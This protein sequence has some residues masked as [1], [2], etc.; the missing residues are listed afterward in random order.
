M[1]ETLN[2]PGFWIQW[3]RKRGTSNWY[4]Q[5]F[6]AERAVS[7]ADARRVFDRQKQEAVERS[8]PRLVPQ[9]SRGPRIER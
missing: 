3:R 4:V 7:P 6:I 8:R 5:T 1:S 9:P 2:F